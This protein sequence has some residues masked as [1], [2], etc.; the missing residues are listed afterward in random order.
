MNLLY[1]HFPHALR[2]AESSPVFTTYLFFSVFGGFALQ[3]LSPWLLIFFFRFI[4]WIAALRNIYCKSCSDIDQLDI[5]K[6]SIPPPNACFPPIIPI[7]IG[8]SVPFKK[9]PIRKYYRDTIMQNITWIFH[10][11]RGIIGNIYNSDPIITNCTLSV[12]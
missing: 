8:N 4:S 2:I 12:T 9:Q 7:S 11:G 6:P 10:N 5:S 1:S 3:H